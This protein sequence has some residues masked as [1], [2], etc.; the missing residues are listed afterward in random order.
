MMTSASALAP[1]FFLLKYIDSKMILKIFQSIKE[2]ISTSLSSTDLRSLDLSLRA[3]SV[4][5]S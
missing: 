1:E 2:L 4:E 5:F 3:K